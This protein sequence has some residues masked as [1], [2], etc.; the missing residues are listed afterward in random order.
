VE[1]KRNAITAAIDRGPCRQRPAG[2]TVVEIII[3]HF[4]L[5]FP[6]GVFP[7]RYDWLARLAEI[8]GDIMSDRLVVQFCKWRPVD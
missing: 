3:N 1:N 7:G 8:T 5:P 6:A 2:F 4:V